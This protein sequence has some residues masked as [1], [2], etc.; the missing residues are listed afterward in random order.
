[1]IQFAALGAGAAKELLGLLKDVIDDPD[2]YKKLD[3]LRQLIEKITGKKIEKAGLVALLEE[4]VCGEPFTGEWQGLAGD[5]KRMRFEG[6]WVVQVEP[7]TN[8][9][10]VPDPK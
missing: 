5:A 1:M 2:T 8:P 9:L 4:N 10:W 7:G 3:G 6:G